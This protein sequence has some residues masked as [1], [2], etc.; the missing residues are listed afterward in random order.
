L[1]TT[2]FEV[3]RED[4]RYYTNRKGKR[5]QYTRGFQADVNQTWDYY[6]YTINPAYQRELA[7][8][9]YPTQ[10]Y[11]FLLLAGRLEEKEEMREIFEE[12]LNDHYPGIQVQSFEDFADVY[13]NYMEKVTRLAVAKK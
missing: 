10:K 1:N 8:K 11:D 9:I 3:K 2:F 12:D 6:K 7:E 5:P 13:V 4:K